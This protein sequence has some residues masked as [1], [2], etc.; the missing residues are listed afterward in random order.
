MNR[1][2]PR[3][4]STKVEGIR[5]ARAAYERLQPR[6]GTFEGS[7]LMLLAMITLSSVLFSSWI[8]FRLAKQV[9]EPIA[10]L[11][12]ATAEVGAGNLDV[13]VERGGHDEIA[14]LVDGFNRMATDLQRNR[15]DLERRRT[16]MEIILRGV[17]AGVISLDADFAV[18]TINPPALRLLGVRAGR[19]GRQEDRRDAQRA[20]STRRSRRCYTGWRRARTRRC[21]GRCRSPSPARCGR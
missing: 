1:F 11:A 19:V 15:E 16:Q 20:R 21:A 10:Q 6:R 13:R 2:L 9:T 14:A 17:G 5:S 18:G 7:M 8:G 4:I 12:F 3:S